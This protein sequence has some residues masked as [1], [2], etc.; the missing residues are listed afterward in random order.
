MH[1]TQTGT[2]QGSRRARRPHIILVNLL[3]VLERHLQPQIRH[4]RASCFWDSFHQ[5][6]LSSP[7][8]SLVGA[9]TGYDGQGLR[10]RLT[11]AI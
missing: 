11:L 4:A 10:A 1:S 3:V 6:G 5:F 2:A 8:G 7:R 9:K